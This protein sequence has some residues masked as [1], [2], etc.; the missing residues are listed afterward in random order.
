MKKYLFLVLSSLLVMSSCTNNQTPEEVKPA[1]ARFTYEVKENPLRVEFYNQS[2]NAYH[3][4]WYFGDKQ[5]EWPSGEENPI[6]YYQKYGTY[7]VTLK[8][9]GKTSGINI[10]NVSEITANVEVYKFR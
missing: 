6:H 7:K 1:Y 2:L 3:Y 4:E 8:A 10:I 5:E 9:Y